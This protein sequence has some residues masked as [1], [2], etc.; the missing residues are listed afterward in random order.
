MV[1]RRLAYYPTSPERGEPTGLGVTLLHRIINESPCSSEG[2]RL[3]TFEFLTK[4]RKWRPRRQRPPAVE[5]LFLTSRPSDWIEADVTLG[6]TATD[7]F[8]LT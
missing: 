1:R 4:E 7:C 5:D 3:T 6:Y 2:N 8:N